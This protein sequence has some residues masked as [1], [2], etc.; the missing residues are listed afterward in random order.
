MHFLRAALTSGT[1][2]SIDNWVRLV[3]QTLGFATALW[4]IYQAL[5]ATI[6]V[7]S[8]T[9]VFLSLTLALTFLTYTP[10]RRS[11]PGKLPLHD[12]ILAVMALVAGG[13]FLLKVDEMAMR[14][15]MFD[16]LSP[17]DLAFSTMLLLMLFDCVRRTIGLA[18][19]VIAGLLFLYNL[20]GA[21]MPG[22]IRHN[23][24]SYVHYVE[25]GFFTTEGI[26]G[27]PLRV[28]ATYGFLFVI[29]GTLLH[30]CGG[31]DFFYNLA[32]SVGNR[33]GGPAK[34]AV[35]S[36]GLFGSAS[37]NPV[38]DVVTTGSITIPVMVR[39]GYSREEA[40]AI[41]ATASTGGSIMPPVM[42]A[43]AFI[44]AEFTGIAYGSIALATLIPV[45]VYYLSLY[46]QVH[47]QA[48]RDGIRGDPTQ[49]GGI[50]AVLRRDWLFLLPLVVLVGVLSMGY[51]PSMVAFVSS[52]TIIVVAT[53]RSATRM[54]LRVIFEE[55]AE[56]TQRVLPVAMACAAAGL[57][58]GGITMTGLAN[59]FASIIA[60]T[61]GGNLWLALVTAA[62]MTIVLGMGLPT[63]A[64]YI[65]ASVLIAGI[66]VRMGLSVLQ[67]HM[68]LFY[69]AAMS[70]ITPPVAIASF[71]A[72]ALAGSDPMKTSFAAMRRAIVIFIAPFAF[73]TH[74]PLLLQGTVL[75]IASTAAF[76]VLAVFAMS[77]ANERYMMGNLTRIERVLLVVAALLLFLSP[78]WLQLVGVV[79]M[80]AG[81][82]RNL[83]AWN[84]RRR[85]G[86]TAT[87]ETAR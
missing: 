16:P 85:D 1:R 48:V 73:A 45:M 43:A 72:S 86:E 77:G 69:F 14:I 15:P 25:M 37:G 58:M 26:F 39:N 6:D 78:L 3:I 63:S 33:P 22:L 42:G 67:A 31:G 64:S 30:R 21:Y 9:I 87:S 82:A 74:A 34:I 81:L 29:F 54:S 2:R 75:E 27:T 79:L 4:S 18:M 20:Y 28:A 56:S 57:V 19:C 76:A 66:L 40:A 46:L 36:S 23:G 59:K 49:S 71:A 32:A 62:L 7:V 53:I 41:E 5:W 47:L 70:A 61:S 12:I 8:L 44:M 35:V 60:L 24:I 83:M 80:A 17:W 52:L 50:L 51:S 11:D 38:A 13:Y 84:V 10:T 65:L 68:F 55:L